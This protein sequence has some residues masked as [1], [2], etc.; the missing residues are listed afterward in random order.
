MICKLCKKYKKTSYG[1]DIWS[2][3]PCARL[4]LQSITTHE[5]S[6][7]HK[8]SVKLELACVSTPSIVETVTPPIP[9]KG[10]HQAFRCL[11]FLPKH[12]IPHTTNY[13]PLLDLLATL[14]LT[15]KADIHVA[16]NATYTSDKSIQ[17]CFMLCQILLK[18]VC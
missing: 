15:T 16:K 11:Y 12:R 18:I 6:C 9:R 3:T 2:N 5:N 14:G 17:E 4:R 10:I 1:H 8:D 13:K 7:V